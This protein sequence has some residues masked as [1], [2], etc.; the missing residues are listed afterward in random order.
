MH[1]VVGNYIENSFFGRI[2]WRLDSGKWNTSCVKSYQEY[3][4][5]TANKNKHDFRGSFAVSI[6]SVL[7]LD[8]MRSVRLHT[9]N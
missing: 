7:V 9:I 2:T 3:L 6:D 4:F 1:R 5:S 8:D